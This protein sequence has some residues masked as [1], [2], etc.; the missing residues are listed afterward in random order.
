MR[1]HG[2]H[3]WHRY[4]GLVTLPTPCTYVHSLST[5]V[6]LVRC[7]AWHCMHA[8]QPSWL[9]QSRKPSF[10]AWIQ[11]VLGQSQTLVLQARK[12]TVSV[13][14]ILQFT[15]LRF[16]SV[17]YGTV[18]F[19][20]VPVLYRYFN[21]TVPYGTTTSGN[22]VRRQLSRWQTSSKHAAPCQ[23]PAILITCLLSPQR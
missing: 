22:R 20:T 4:M 5:N 21:H 9:G 15:V 6:V 19:R 10:S 16:G 11:T 13:C 17:R 7:M 14:A 12:R 8:S 23:Y 1:G 3:G 2:R 18:R